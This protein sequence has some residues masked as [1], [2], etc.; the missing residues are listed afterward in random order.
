MSMGVHQV[1][2]DANVMSKFSTR[3]EKQIKF[4]MWGKHITSSSHDNYL[5][6]KCIRP[7]STTYIH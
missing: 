1:L 2:I 5:I 6:K 3:R 7:L 4:E